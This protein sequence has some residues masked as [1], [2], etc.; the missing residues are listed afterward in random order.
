VEDDETWVA[1]LERILDTRVLNAD[2]GAYGIDQA[3]L[4]AELLLDQYHPKVV[5]IL[6]R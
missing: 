6:R 3:V 4:R 1:F 5:T 2:V